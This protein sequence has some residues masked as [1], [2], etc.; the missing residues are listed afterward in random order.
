[1]PERKW[2]SLASALA[3][4]I[5]YELS[6]PETVTAFFHLGQEVRD[7]AGKMMASQIVQ[8]ALRSGS[9]CTVFWLVK[10]CDC[11]P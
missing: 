9:Y 8:I 2:A 5:E 6:A 1:M 10:P 11:Q 3:C 4:L 7:S